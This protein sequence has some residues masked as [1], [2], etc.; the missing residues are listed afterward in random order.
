MCIRALCDITRTISRTW[1]WVLTLDLRLVH[2]KVVVVAAALVLLAG[3][4][5]QTLVLVLHV[6]QGEGGR[7]QPAVAAL[8]GQDGQRLLLWWRGQCSEASDPDPREG[9]ETAEPPPTCC[10]QTSTHRSTDMLWI[11]SL[12][13]RASWMLSGRWKQP[14]SR[15]LPSERQQY[16]NLDVFSG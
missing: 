11:T 8:P 9:K 15:A 4:A 3:A 12:K 10:V 2:H 14:L 1:T 13:G 6:V 7:G 16:K 5:L